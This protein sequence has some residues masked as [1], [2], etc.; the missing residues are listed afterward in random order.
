MRMIVPALALLLCPPLPAFAAREADLPSSPDS[1]YIKV[2][3]GPWLTGGMDRWQTSFPLIP[4][5][6]K[7]QLGFGS[8]LEFNDPHDLLWLWSVE[9]RPVRRVSVEFQYA[10][11]SS[12]G[13]QSHDHDW[14]SAPNGVV[15]ALPSGD[16]Y[17]NPEQ[18]D[19]SRSQ[20]DLSGRTTFI[21][22][23]LFGR[24]YEYDNP[25]QVEW[26][27]HQYL[28]VLLGYSWYDDKYRMKNLVQIVSTGDF[29]DTPPPGPIAGQDSTFRF[30]YEGFKI[31]AREDA[32]ITEHLRIIALFAFSPFMTYHGEAYW[33]LRTDFTSTPPSFTQSA[34]A[35][36]FEGRFTLRYV[37]VKYFTAEAG[38]M[39]V[40]IRTNPGGQMTTYLAN[41]TS[42]TQDLD[43]AW[44]ERKGF[45]L[46]LALKF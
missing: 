31:G 7:S 20:S 16:V 6:P 12:V 34:T 13:G 23:N 37:P 41:G 39:L 8:T 35:D 36:L 26:M 25:N 4:G 21:S 1:E 9:V 28:D 14:L 29:I 17:V 5:I 30:H 46:N 38:Y 10:D 19:M 32:G 18:T 40:Y 11:S 45:M 44:S 3:G 15:T 22:A 27:I 42:V 33:N 24:V 2:S 43:S